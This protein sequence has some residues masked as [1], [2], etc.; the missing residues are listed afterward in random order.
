MQLQSKLEEMRIIT[1]SLSF[2]LSLSRIPGKVNPFYPDWYVNWR[3]V[4]TEL[5][6]ISSLRENYREVATTS[7][8]TPVVVARDPLGQRGVNRYRPLEISNPKLRGNGLIYKRPR[9]TERYEAWK[10]G[11]SMGSVV[12]WGPVFN[13]LA[14]SR[15]CNYPP[16]VFC[17][18]EE[19]NNV[20]TVVSRG[21]L[22]VSFHRRWNF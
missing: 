10:N 21:G 16:S 17:R 14:L 12:F 6:L 1:R 7:R 20:V 13:P 19:W 2:S 22:A 3:V 15:P 9:Y 5:P 4:L 8:E 18:R 11:S